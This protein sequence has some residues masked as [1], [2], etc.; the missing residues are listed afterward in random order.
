VAVSAVYFIASVFAWV[1][2]SGLLWA[3]EVEARRM[4][5]DQMGGSHYDLE[6]SGG[7]VAFTSQ[8]RR[9]G[10]HVPQ[11]YLTQWHIDWAR[12]PKIEG[13]W[14]PNYSYPGYFLS[15][16]RKPILGFR[17]WSDHF[18]GQASADT[19]SEH[20]VIVPCWSLVILFGILPSLW[21]SK[22]RKRRNRNTA[23]CLACGYNLTGNSSGV[24]PECGHEI[25]KSATSLRG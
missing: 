20:G 21:V 22:N 10:P 12:L 8:S 24:C 25:A 6:L 3:C 14:K 17:I 2:E 15:D 23:E 13:R 16:N 1:C 5:T 11:K 19:S 4:H 18:I 9:L 7:G